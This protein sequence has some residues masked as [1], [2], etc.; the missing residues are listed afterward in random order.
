M[1][2]ARCISVVTAFA[3]GA[4]GRRI[5]SSRGG[6]IEIFIVPAS[7]PRLSWYVLSCMFDDAYKRTLAACHGGVGEGSNSVIS[8]RLLTPSF[9]NQIRIP[10]VLNKYQISLYRV[11]SYRIWLGS[12]GIQGIRSSMQ[13]Y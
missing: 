9:R 1:W 5:D 10:R 7:A 12:K 2:G 6:P 8:D 4:I 11:N 13:L 3:H